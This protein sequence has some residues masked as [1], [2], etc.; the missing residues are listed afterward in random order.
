MLSTNKRETIILLIGDVLGL[1]LSLFLSLYLR[2]FEIPT[3]ETLFISIPPWSFIF[4]IT[5]LSF[6]IAGL[7]EK[8]RSMLRKKI[9]ELLFN[10]EI[11]NSVVA[12]VFFYFTPFFGVAPK[13]ILF[14]YIIVSFLVLFSWRML[15]INLFFSREKENAILIARGEESQLLEKEINENPRYSFKIISRIDIETKG[16]D[17]DKDVLEKIEKENVKILIVDSV[18]QKISGF[19]PNF[20]NLIFSRITFLE[21]HDLYEEVFDRVPVSL[22]DYSWFLEHISASPR[23]VYDVLKRLMDI[24]I[25]IPLFIISL[26]FYP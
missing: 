25:S 16:L 19:L 11:I 15:A 9:P 8:H 20:Y 21:M 12:I 3:I 1:F 5:I 26:I 13:T 6:F 2:S 18:D 10:T 4:S 14:I 17:F 7:Y 22:L 23:E 24:L